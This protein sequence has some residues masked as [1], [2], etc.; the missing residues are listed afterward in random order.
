MLRDILLDWILFTFWENL[1][2]VMFITNDFNRKYQKYYTVLG[3]FVFSFINS[4]IYCWIN[5]LTI[6][7]LNQ[8]YYFISIIIFIKLFYKIKIVNL[9]VR[10]MVIYGIIF[11][12]D[13]MMMFIL[14]EILNFTNVCDSVWMVFLHLIPCK[15]FEFSVAMKGCDELMKM[16]WGSIERR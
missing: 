9:I 16:T 7:F 8:V 11:I 4:V 15:L 12:T 3:F 14:M 6:P 13:T 1:I 2:C 10:L 5:I